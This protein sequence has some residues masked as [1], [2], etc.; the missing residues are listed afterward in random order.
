MQIFNVSLLGMQMI[1]WALS[2]ENV[3]S[4]I[5]DQVWLKPACS[6]TATS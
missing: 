5:F 3:F 2:R 1:K 6:A 4:E